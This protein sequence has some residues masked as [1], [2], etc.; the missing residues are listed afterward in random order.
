M[1]SHRII[2][3][4]FYIWSLP[5]TPVSL[6]LQI[7]DSTSLSTCPLACASHI[8]AGAENQHTSKFH[9]FIKPQPSQTL[10]D[11]LPAIV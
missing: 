5:S 8:K 3:E 2:K 10:P 9:C 7:L 1:T 11:I 4:L 6:V